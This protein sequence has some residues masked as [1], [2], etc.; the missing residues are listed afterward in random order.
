MDNKKE[1]PTEVIHKEIDLIQS[2]ISRIS[3]YSFLIKGWLISL[4][5]VMLTISVN[6]D[7]IL[8]ISIIS[9]ITIFSFWYLDAFLLWTE[10]KYREMYIWVLEQRKKGNDDELYNLNP[11][12]FSKNVGSVKTAMFSRTLCC[13]YGIP[14][15]LIIVL[16]ILS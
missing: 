8:I 7:N 12:R 2:C 16:I 6:K 1:I 14:I 5:A 15:L 10:K 3:N 11:D 4:I 9:I 13:F